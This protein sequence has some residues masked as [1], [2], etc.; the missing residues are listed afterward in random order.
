MGVES[1]S[2]RRWGARVVRDAIETVKTSPA[3]GDGEGID[4]VAAA[5]AHLR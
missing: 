4:A 1:W 3:G 2:P 5:R